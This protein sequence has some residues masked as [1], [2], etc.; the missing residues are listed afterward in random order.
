MT[1]ITSVH[2]NRT[3]QQMRKRELLEFAGGVVTIRD[4]EALKQTADFDD[5]YLYLQRQVR[6]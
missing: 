1:G 5:S 6:R 2:A 3:L 4:L